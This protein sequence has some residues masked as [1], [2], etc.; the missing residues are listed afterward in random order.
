MTGSLR[1]WAEGN[2]RPI[3]ITLDVLVWVVSILTATWLRFE[4]LLGVPDWGNVAIA[5]LVVVSAHLALAGSLRLYTG[6]HRVGAYEDAFAVAL[7][8]VAAAL[9]LQV[10]SFLWPGG[11]LMPLSVPLAAGTAAVLG[12]V[13]GRVLMRR[14]R[15]S[16]RRPHQAQRV[17]V[18]GA[19]NVGTK[20]VRD[21]VTDPTSPYVPVAFVDDHPGKQHF[22]SSGVRV[23]G[24]LD[25]VGRLS[26][27]L[28]VSLVIVAVGDPDPA[29]LRRVNDQAESSRS[30]CQGRA[31][32]AADAAVGHLAR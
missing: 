27:D 5:T 18:V 13:G 1:D 23:L 6:R 21:M 24:D 16:A 11:R 9:L 15:E 10:I 28:D 4:V 14:V 2:R 25:D 30:R 26:G 29:L 20:L 22:R 32:A 7:V 19:G 8:T 3:L 12:T 31:D 17:L